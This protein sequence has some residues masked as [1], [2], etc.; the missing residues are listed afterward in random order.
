MQ[1]WH[2]AEFPCGPLKLFVFF[3]GGG[4]LDESMSKALDHS[5]NLPQ[6][7]DRRGSNTHGLP[8]VI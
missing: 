2:R 1:M 7:K 6:W 8:R 4:G 5:S 3:G